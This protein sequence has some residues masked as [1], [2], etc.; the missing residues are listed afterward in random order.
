MNSEATP[1][2]SEPRKAI[3]LFYDGQRAPRVSALGED[4]VAEEIVRIAREAGVPLY[5][6]EALLRS[7]AGLELGDTIPELLYRA[8]A[9][10]IAF[11]Y[12]V[13]GKTPAD[14]GHTGSDRSAS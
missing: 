10:V 1:P 4:A 3:A 12:L 13:R 2:P 8:I 11:A 6:D 14:V 7:L 9:E 5:E